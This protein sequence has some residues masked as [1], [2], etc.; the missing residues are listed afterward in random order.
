[1]SLNQKKLK[2]GNRL[3]QLEGIIEQKYSIIWDC[4][5]D[6]GLL[7]MSLLQGHAADKVI[8]VDILAKQMALL[9]S[10]LTQYFSA[11]EFDWEVICKDLKELKVPDDD[12]QLFIIAGVGG[13]KTIE[14]INNLRAYSFIPNFDLLV[15]SVHGNYQVRQTLTSQGFYLINEQIVM[16]NNRFYEII[17]ASTKAEAKQKITK[18]GSSMWDWSNP[19]HLNYWKKI[20]AHY[21]I[22]AKTNPVHY[23]SILDDYERL[24]RFEL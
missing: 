7:G 3:R 13:D 21:R 1:M 10:K 11:D 2:L 15:C 4:C 18:V 6:H 19:E 9:E 8:F 24:N 14:F 17:Y 23:H 5:C 16:E 20:I 22:K 12:S